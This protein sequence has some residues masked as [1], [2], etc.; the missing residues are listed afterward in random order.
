MPTPFILLLM[1]TVAALIGFGVGVGGRVVHRRLQVAQADKKLPAVP[2]S[3][4]KPILD[5]PPH[6]Q[7]QVRW[8]LVTNPLPMWVYDP[9][10]FR[11]LDVNESAIAQ[12]GYSR[13]HFLSMTLLDLCLPEDNPKL[14]T[15]TAEP[16]AENVLWRDHGHWRHIMHGGQ[17][18][19]VRLLTHRSEFGGQS[20]YFATVQDIS[21]QIQAQATLASREAWWRAII[22]YSADMVIV[23]DAALS[24]VYASTSVTKTLGYPVAE[25][26][27]SAGIEWLRIV[28]ERS[29]VLLRW[30][31]KM[32][33]GQPFSASEFGVP[34]ELRIRDY[35]GEWHWLEVMLTRL[36]VPPL[37]GVIVNARDITARV[38]ADKSL[39]AANENLKA[40]IQFAPTP[41]I[42]LNRDQQ[43]MVWNPAAEKLFGWTV[44]EVM[45]RALP[46][47]LTA[48]VLS[49]DGV[50]DAP[51]STDQRLSLLDVTRSGRTIQM[52]SHRRDRSAL[53][54][55]VS[56]GFIRD[57]VATFN[58]T[59]SVLIDTT[60]QQQAQT[61]LRQQ[62]DYLSALH[63]TA[64]A[65]LNRPN[66]SQLLVAILNR[67]AEFLNTPNGYLA[68]IDPLTGRVPLQTGIGFYEKVLGMSV[69]SNEGLIG[70]VLATNQPFVVDDYSAWEPHLDILPGQHIYAAV[71]MP[72]TVKGR[73]IGVIGVVRLTPGPFT[74]DEISQLRH[75]VELAC[76]ALDN[77]SL[78]DEAQKEL[79]ERARAEADLQ[80]LNAE[81]E[82]RIEARTTL[83][84]QREIELRTV[85]DSMGEG[86]IY[87]QADSHSLY[88]EFAN[89]MLSELLGYQ[90]DDLLGQPFNMLEPLEPLN[91]TIWQT[92]TEE[93]RTAAWRVES[94]WKR[95]DGRRL[96]V[97]LSVRK[98]QANIG[99][100]NKAIRG[101]MVVRDVTDEKQL[102]EQKTRFIANAS[103]ELRTPLTHL[104]TRLYLIRRQPEH[105]EEHLAVLEQS[106]RRMTTL[107]EDMLDI[108]RFEQ[109]WGQLNLH[110]VTIQTLLAE[111]L[112][113]LQP[114]LDLKHIQLTVN[115]P[116][117][118][119]NISADSD[120]LLQVLTNLAVNAINYTGENGHIAIRMQPHDQGTLIEFEDSGI[121]VAPENLERI[122]E[123]FF[124][125]EL[126]TGRGMSLGLGL[127]IAREIT[128]LHGGHLSI[129]SQLN[130][131]STFRLWLPQMPPAA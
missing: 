26:T 42:A 75:L 122:F 69:A 90:P 65:L 98:V 44:S 64:V 45:G 66:V 8:M 108:T 2:D 111:L 121:G 27:G 21:S 38:E 94:S 53:S 31:N 60:S 61:R 88:I 72:L 131:G 51:D 114:E 22:E 127:T 3:A 82:Q 12:Y 117:T 18:M 77:A 113:D 9:Q 74:P 115:Q 20:V 48:A 96:V 91:N 54:L 58:G 125:V 100:D 49:D 112:A 10:T 99:T 128:L 97:A 103:H 93:S 50:F 33:S 4:L 35:A 71:G 23:I 70:Q 120:R 59:I 63:D 73:A 6:T 87:F 13:T 118:P 119:L 29:P 92:L 79:T 7:E 5:G 19:D 11:I 107:I 57:T 52:N 80:R 105:A 24:V 14:K 76:L 16:L 43:V 89:R 25:I 78:Y 30:Q 67:A 34:L 40:L 130:V 56:T 17:M 84:L 109:G 83:L 104:K 81:L 85:I 62:F 101:V 124:R 28:D 116:D 106:I 86:L 47:T 1:V 95:A 32:L 55:S 110:P 39:F 123:P 68:L 129:R 37:S 126:G 46:M 36:N 102:A 41:I 15:E